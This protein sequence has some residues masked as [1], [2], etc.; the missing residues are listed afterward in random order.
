MRSSGLEPA[1][2]C[3][4]R[5]A[6]I[7]RTLIGLNEY[8]ICPAHE[9]LITAV[10]PARRHDVYDLAPRGV[11]HATKLVKKQNQIGVVFQPISGSATVTP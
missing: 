2:A 3:E 8:E 4:R 9:L 6:R 11:D 5:C 7:D 10:R 1:L